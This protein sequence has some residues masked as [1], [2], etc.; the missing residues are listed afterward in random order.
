MHVSGH[1]SQEELKIV[2]SLVRPR[3]FVPVHGEYRHLVHHARLAQSLGMPPER[4]V[5]LENGT[6]LIVSANGCRM[7]EPVESG[8]VFVDG[9][10]VGDVGAME[11]RDRRHLANHG[12]V[13]VFLALNQ[14]SGGIVFGP[15]LFT[16]GFVPAEESQDYLEQARQVVR[17][18]LAEHSLEALSDWE[19]LRVTV[20]KTLQ[21]FFNRTRQ[22][23]PLILPVILEL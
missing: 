7:E 11:L 5:I 12:L 3:F 10:G 18:L 17:D 14:S 23:R 19:E 16:R 8:R 21:R 4:T 2:H 22:R 20:R 1:A 9:K 13:V 15:E 6:P